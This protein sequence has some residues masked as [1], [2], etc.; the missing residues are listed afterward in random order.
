MFKMAAILSSL[1]TLSAEVIPKV[2]YTRKFRFWKFFFLNF[3]FGQNVWKKK[4]IDFKP[5][6]RKSRLQSKLSKNFDFG[7]KFKKSRFRSKF[8]KNFYFGLK[9]R[10]S[11]LRST[12]KKKNDFSTKFRKCRLQSKFS[13]N[14][15]ISV[16]EEIIFSPNFR[17]V[18]L[19]KKI[20]F[21][22]KILKISIS[23]KIFEKIRFRSKIWKISISVKFFTKIGNRLNAKFRKSRLKWN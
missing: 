13:K 11:W 7:L 21:P 19:R 5:K 12:F 14:K 22:S 20:R 2:E 17:K 23:V 16:Q 15:S 10:K 18:W 6:F 8:S 4:E 9:F 3:H 1:Q